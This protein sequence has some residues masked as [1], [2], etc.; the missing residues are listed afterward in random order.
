MAYDRAMGEPRSVIA[1]PRG[2]VFRRSAVDPPPVAVSASG[3]TIRDSTGREYLDAAGGALVVN[4]GHGRAEI[5]A[6][7]ADQAGRL[8]Y[9]HG[10]TFTTE[11]LEA[12]ATEVAA[13]LPVDDPAIYPVSGG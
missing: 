5:A 4:V 3:S 6:I 9:A 7:M 12:Y 2:R 13:V 11:P 10:S 8:A 1:P